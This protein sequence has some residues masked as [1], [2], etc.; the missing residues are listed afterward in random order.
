LENFF[1]KT[2]KFNPIKA[3]NAGSTHPKLAF[4]NGMKFLIPTKYALGITKPKKSG[5]LNKKVTKTTPLNTCFE[6]GRAHV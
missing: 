2:V 6:I 4:A 3:K 1:I 5:I